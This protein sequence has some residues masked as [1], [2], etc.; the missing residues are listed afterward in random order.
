MVQ[1]DATISMFAPSVTAAKVPRERGISKLT[2]RVGRATP[3]KSLV[4]ELVHV[5][6][7][8]QNLFYGITNSQQQRGYRIDFGRLLLEVCRDTNGK[9]RG[10]ASAYIAGVIPDDDSFWKVAEL[11]GF[12]VRRG[13]LGSGNRSKQDDAFLISEIVETV[14]MQAGPSTVILVAGDADYVP[15]L[16]KSQDRGWRNEVAFIDRGLAIALE[17]YY[18]DFRTLVLA[19]SNY[20][21]NNR[22]RP[23]CL[24]SPPL[25]ADV[26]LCVHPA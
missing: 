15:P 14:C 19:V 18:H 7:D 1:L 3:H 22:E 11:N 13:Y 9:A 10:V 6:V 23:P 17:A 5:F 8:D 4:N 20:L 26:A 16:I 2:Y 24:C 21:S 25:F 12:T